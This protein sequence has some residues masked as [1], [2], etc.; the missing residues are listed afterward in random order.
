MIYI[1]RRLRVNIIF[2]IITHFG[3]RFL[4]RGVYQKH[5]IFSFII[6]PLLH[7]FKIYSVIV[8]PQSLHSI[9]YHSKPIAPLF[10]ILYLVKTQK[11]SKYISI[12]REGELGLVVALFSFSFQPLFSY[13]YSSMQ[14]SSLLVRS[15]VCKIGREW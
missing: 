10:L 9:G 6:K 8:Q 12:T 13:I 15:Y 5:C 4:E 7:H 1:C 2:V 11:L 14:S 3:S